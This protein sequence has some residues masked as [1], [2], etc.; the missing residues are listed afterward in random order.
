M[1]DTSQFTIENGERHLWN[2]A[3]GK[4]AWWKWQAP[5][6]GVLQVHAYSIDPHIR[7]IVAVHDGPALR[8]LRVALSPIAGRSAYVELPTQNM[9]YAITVDAL[10]RGGHITLD[11][12]FTPAPNAPAAVMGS[13]AYLQAAYLGGARA[14]GVINTARLTNE[15]GEPLPF[16][17][18]DFKTAWWRWRAP[19]G[20]IYTVTAD[21]PGAQV[22][23]AV[24][25]DTPAT[26]FQRVAA[27]TSA[28]VGVAASVPFTA[29]AGQ[30]YS[31]LVDTVEFGPPNVNITLRISP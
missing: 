9:E 5:G 3:A 13:D 31:F 15:S 20:G 21:G 1:A 16:R 27:G 10:D 2:H 18:C 29:I 26:P 19:S 23:V 11:L 22:G 24:Y 17:H 7:P 30:E 8:F 6:P 28:T 4:T 12:E 14:V 25:M